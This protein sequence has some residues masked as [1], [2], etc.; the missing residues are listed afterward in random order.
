MS[1]STANTT[2]VFGSLAW[3]PTERFTAES[4]AA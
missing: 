4:S 3:D 1:T 2:T